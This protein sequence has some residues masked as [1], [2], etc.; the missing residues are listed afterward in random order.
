MFDTKLGD[1]IRVYK[2]FY[3][4]NFCLDLVNNLK[5]AI[6]TTHSYYNPS[7]KTSRS[8]D[9]ELE[10]SNTNIPLKKQLDDKIKNALNQYVKK[11]ME[12]LVW[13]NEWNGHTPCRFN[14]YEPQAKMR[15]HCDHIHTVF[16]GKRK[17]IP[18]LTVLGALNDDYE[19]GKLFLCGK[20]IE[21]KTGDIVVFPSN[22]LYPH[23]VEPVTSGTRYSFVV[24]AW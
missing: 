13:Y 9:N 4:S 1:Y 5:D 17:G 24:W 23:E 7:L 8:F 11:D 12:H 10:V 18:V 20:H 2:Q 16:D 22:F 21:L 19:G 15:L 3:T 14:K 6:W